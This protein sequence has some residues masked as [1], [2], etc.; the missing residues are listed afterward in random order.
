MIRVCV[1]NENDVD[2]TEARI[3]S[4]GYSIARIVKNADS[5]GVFK[6]NRPILRAELACALA[7]RRDLHILRLRN[8]ACHC[9][10]DH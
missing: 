10:D 7:D 6:E 5:C 2:L 8:L 4:T 1:R 3:Y 9:H